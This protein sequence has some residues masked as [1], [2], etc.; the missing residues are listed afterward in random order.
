MPYTEK[1]RTAAHTE[2]ARRE[3]G[4]RP[5]KFKGMDLPEL[6]KYAREPLK[7]KK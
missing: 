6:R 2:I 1:Q 4:V 3:R 5:Q 7:E